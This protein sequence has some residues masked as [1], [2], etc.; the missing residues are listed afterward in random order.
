MREFVIKQWNG[1][2]FGKAEHALPEDAPPSDPCHEP[3]VI[4]AEPPTLDEIPRPA[5]EPTEVAPREDEVEAE[6]EALE[7]PVPPRPARRRGERNFVVAYDGRFVGVFEAEEELTPREAF[8]RV[9]GDLSCRKNFDPEKLQLYKPVLLRSARPPKGSKF[10]SG[11]LTEIGGRIH[12]GPVQDGSDK[13]AAGAP[14][15]STEARVEPE[16][17]ESPVEEKACLQLP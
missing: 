16:T 12:E 11:K 7:P 10:V 13:G 5:S 3:I 9:A 6:L 4:I 14:P 1:L 8:L 2:G 17:S 15:G